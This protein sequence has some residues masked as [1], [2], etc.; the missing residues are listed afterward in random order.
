MSSD[1]RS[2][3][4]CFTINNYTEEDENIVYAMSWD[5][6][7]IVCGRE[8][9]ESGTPHLQ[10]YIYYKTLVSLKQMKEVHPTAHWEPQRGTPQ[11]AS[12]Y[13]KK[14]GDFYEC[15]NIPM[16]QQKKGEA[17]A[18]R[19]EA[20]RQAV[21][22]GRIADIPADICIHLAKLEYAVSREQLAERSLADTE[23]PM[24]W[25]YGDSGTGKSRKAR[26]DN[27]S[28]YLKM[29]NKWW[30]GYNG[31]DTVIIE[32]FDK[33]H[34]V[35]CHHLKIWADRYPF[36]AE[37]KGGKIDI[38]PKKIIVTSNYHPRDIWVDERDL[39]PILRRFKIEHFTKF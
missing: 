6:A 28:A 32:D 10:G 22:E 30:D 26:T 8:V 38:R 27:P 15:G 20:A 17:N 7:Y 33:E 16:S 1:G 5:C 12:D 14:E 4:W 37:V 23:E 34:H 11:E 36:P 25:Y 29:C 19:W 35:L 18:E 13:C 2:R 21:R 9:G 24:L 31:Q 3:G 39:N